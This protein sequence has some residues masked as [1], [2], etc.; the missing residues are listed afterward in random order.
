MERVIV[1]GANGF[2]GGTL[3]NNLLKKGVKVVAIDITFAIGNFCL[4]FVSAGIL[5]N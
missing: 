1:T 4:S 5:G 3:V 2:I